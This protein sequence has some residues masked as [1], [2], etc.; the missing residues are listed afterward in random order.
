MTRHG[1]YKQN[2]VGAVFNANT[3]IGRKNTDLF[4]T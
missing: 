4:M 3:K 1:Y 2:V